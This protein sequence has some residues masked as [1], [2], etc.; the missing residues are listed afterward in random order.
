[1]SSLTPL[2]SPSLRPRAQ[3]QPVAARPKERAPVPVALVSAAP[4]VPAAEQQ[5]IAIENLTP[6]MWSG[7]RP[8]RSMR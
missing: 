2:W 5:R 3:Q 1:M 8:R 4:S 7:R 6:T